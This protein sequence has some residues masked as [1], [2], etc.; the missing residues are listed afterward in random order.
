MDNFNFQLDQ[1]DAA[2]RDVV[3]I[4]KNH[5]DRLMA[6]GFSEQEALTM[7]VAMQNSILSWGRSK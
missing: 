2:M 1:F 6:I 3:P 7:T 5:Y 4:L